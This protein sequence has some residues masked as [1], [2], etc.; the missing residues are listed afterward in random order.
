[1]KSETFLTILGEV[2]ESLLAR[3]EAPPHSTRRRFVKS[4]SAFAALF[5]VAVIG[6]SV[7]VM[8]G[9]GNGAG[10]A[11]SGAGGGDGLSYMNYIG[12]VLPLTV[13]DGGEGIT[14]CLVNCCLNDTVIILR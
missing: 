11:G 5:A 2:D 1:M 6:V 14:R 8:M 7:G 10:A 9:I 3:C 13:L 4:L 12:P